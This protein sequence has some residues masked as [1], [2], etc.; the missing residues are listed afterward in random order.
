MSESA[1]LSRLIT[2]WERGGGRGEGGWGDLY[3]GR[4][5]EFIS[6]SLS[7]DGWC[8][9]RRDMGVYLLAALRDVD[10]GLRRVGEWEC[11]G[12]C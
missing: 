6:L 2:I 11:S 3:F 12:L 5:A 4:G 9:E 8:V 10:E 1:E 7:L